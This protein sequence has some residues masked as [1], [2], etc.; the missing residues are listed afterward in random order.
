MLPKQLEETLLEI[1]DVT[2]NT[3]NH[4]CQHS[5]VSR[6]RR[7]GIVEFLASQVLRICYDRVNQ[8]EDDI[9]KKLCSAF[10]T[11]KKG[12]FVHHH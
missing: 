6:T 10:I 4:H 3:A 7:T 5:S 2:Q 1:I 11:T 12:S 8:I 9:T